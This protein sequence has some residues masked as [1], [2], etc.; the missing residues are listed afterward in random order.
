[1]DHWIFCSGCPESFHSN[2]KRNFK[3]KL[4][5]SLTKLLQLDKT[6]TTAFHPQSNAVTEKT[7]RTLPNMW[8]KMT[9]KNQRN[10]SEVLPYVMPPY[11]ISVHKSTGWLHALPLTVR[12]WS[13]PA[14]I[15]VFPPPSDVTWTNYHKYV[16]ELRFCFHTTYEQ[17]RQYLKGQQKRQHSPFNA[18]VHGPT[19]TEGQLVFLENPSVPERLSPKLHFFWRGTYKIRQVISEVTYRKCKIETNEEL[20]VHYLWNLAVR[21]LVVSYL[22][23]T[24]LLH[25]CNCQM[26]SLS[27]LPLQSFIVV[28]MKLI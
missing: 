23:R 21:F 8:A 19:Y 17:A 14:N 26:R 28:S 10:W 15:P 7:N 20:I 11:R 16:A 24:H 9:D 25:Q 27:N 13:L 6:R 12:P 4:L 2:Q 5:T 22:L 18:K 1:M 3:A